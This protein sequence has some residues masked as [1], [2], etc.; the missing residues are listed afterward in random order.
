MRFPS[1]S[2]DTAKRQT[3][4]RPRQ[5]RWKHGRALLDTLAQPC[6]APPHGNRKGPGAKLNF[7]LRR[8][9]VRWVRGH[10]P[11]QTGRGSSAAGPCGPSGAYFRRIGPTSLLR[12]MR[13]R[14]DGFLKKQWARVPTPS[15]RLGDWHYRSRAPRRP[16]YILT[17]FVIQT[18][19]CCPCCTHP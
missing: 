19:H 3:H 14:R 15:D 5:G 8:A 2:T 4:H 13:R 17:R 9:D 10:G 7:G 11:A 1:G 6:L 12:A 16:C 18:M